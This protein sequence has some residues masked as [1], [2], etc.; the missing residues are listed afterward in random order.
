MPDTYSSMGPRSYEGFAIIVLALGA[1]V[2]AGL[3]WIIL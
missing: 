2:V 3:V 1:L